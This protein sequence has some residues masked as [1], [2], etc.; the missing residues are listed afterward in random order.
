MNSTSKS[1]GGVGKQQAKQGGRKDEGRKNAGTALYDWFIAVFGVAFLLS[2]SLNMMH[3]SMGENDTNDIGR[4]GHSSNKR[5]ARAALHQAIGD[6]RKGLTEVEQHQIKPSGNKGPKAPKEGDGNQD[7]F[8]KLATLDCESTSTK[9]DNVG[10][11]EV[12]RRPPSLLTGWRHDGFLVDRPE[13][14]IAVT[15][16]TQCSLDRLPNMKEQ[17]FNWKGRASIAV[18]LKPSE[19]TKKAA[20]DI[21][22]ALDNGKASNSLDVAITLVKGYKEGESYPINYLRNIALLESQKQHLR[23]APSLDEAAV[24]LGKF[25]LFDHC[26]FLSRTQSFSDLLAYCRRS[27]F[28]P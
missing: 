28:S 9:A 2:F 21:L 13:D 20:S 27:V 10:L 26:C 6:F 1:S 15:L 17:L 23:F 25:Y 8:M 12:S 4:M 18:Y 24:L 5:A 3:L 14:D 19:D 11:S 7:S 16:V 22:A